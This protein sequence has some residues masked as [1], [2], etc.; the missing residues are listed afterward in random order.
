MTQPPKGVNIAIPPMTEEQARALRDRYRKKNTA[1]AVVALAL[2]LAGIWA[3]G[4]VI[5]AANK[6]KRTRK[7]A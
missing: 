6:P 2:A 4:E 5:E 1:D 7:R 3:L